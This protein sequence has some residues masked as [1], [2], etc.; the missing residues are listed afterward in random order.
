MPD[1]DSLS[2]FKKTCRRLFP[3]ISLETKTNKRFAKTLAQKQ[4]D[5]D[6]SWSKL[7]L[8]EWLL[9]IQLTFWDIKDLT[10]AY[11]SSLSLSRAQK[12]S[13]SDKRDPI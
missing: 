11:K 3:S 12:I 4:R 6:L 1:A 7:Q 13:L 8:R 9:V 10:D 2:V 5:E